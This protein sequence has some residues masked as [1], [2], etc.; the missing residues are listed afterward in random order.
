MR[1]QGEGIASDEINVGKAERRKAFPISKRNRFG[2]LMKVLY[3]F[4]HVNRIPQNNRIEDKAQG[5]RVL[6]ALYEALLGRPFV[7]A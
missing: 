6:S 2:L 4:T 3:S 7:P 1:D 5:Q